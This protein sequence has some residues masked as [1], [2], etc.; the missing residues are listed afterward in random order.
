MLTF[1]EF[2][3]TRTEH[4]VREGARHLRISEDYFEGALGILIYE[5]DL[6]IEETSGP[7]PYVVYADRSFDEFD[8][9][10]AAEQFLYDNAY[11]EM[12]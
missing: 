9:L 3:E 12:V 11:L 4:G 6:Y 10:A 1:E 5:N 7:N 8:S 2:Q